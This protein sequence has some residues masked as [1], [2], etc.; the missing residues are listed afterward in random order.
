MP[1]PK[2]AFFRSDRLSWWRAS[3]LGV[4]LRMR[5]KFRRQPGFVLA[6][7][8]GSAGLILAL[9]LLAGNVRAPEGDPSA[10]ADLV[11]S[12]GNASDPS[13]A[14]GDELAANLESGG[15]SSNDRDGD[16]FGS[17]ELPAPKA[18]ASARR[19][20]AQPVSDRRK[21]FDDIVDLDEEQPQKPLTL[22]PKTASPAAEEKPA[23]R[24]LTLPIVVRDN[25]DVATELAADE[26]KPQKE[27]EKDDTETDALDPAEAFP[28]LPATRRN[29][30]LSRSLDDE[31]TGPSARAASKAEASPPFR[32]ETPA[33]PRSAAAAS[34]SSNDDPDP[35]VR[36]ID[37]SPPRTVVKQPQVPKVIED[38]PEADPSGDLFLEPRKAVA[39]EPAHKTDEPAGDEATAEPIRSREVETAVY[40]TEPAKEVG[41]KSA[42][43]KAP[44]ARRPADPESEDARESPL[45]IRIVAPKRVA[46]GQTFD[47]DL[48]VYNDGRSTVRNAMLTVNLP[49]ELSHPN[50]PDLEQKINSIPACGM[51][52]GRLTVKA[53]ASGE[54]PL[55]TSVTVRGN[56]SA[57]S[58]LALRIGES[59]PTRVS[60]LPPCGCMPIPSVRY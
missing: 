59:R 33:R 1:L 53:S 10:D 48:I 34:Q 15:N 46:A 44:P 8:A 25:A 26:G 5:S 40:A 4:W 38:E 27:L 56:V 47:I 11:P 19:P 51:H 39:S 55:R 17:P 30:S 18:S 22:R 20:T 45:T 31:E 50:G 24:K 43:P 3:S 49:E 36:V 14:S 54:F 13:D 37:R 28:S 21:A 7:T 16:P 52:R 2:P 9:V 41:S 23:A 57:K 42:P 12:L 60:D 58:T 29:G 6:A 35:D 32:R